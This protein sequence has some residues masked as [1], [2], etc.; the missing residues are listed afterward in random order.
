MSLFGHR[1]V[2][3]VNERQ[4]ETRRN[5]LGQG[6]QLEL[7]RMFLHHKNMVNFACN[8]FW[9]KGE[10]CQCANMHDWSV[11]LFALRTELL[12][13]EPTKEYIPILLGAKKMMDTQVESPCPIIDNCK[14]QRCWTSAPK[15]QAN[16]ERPLV[17]SQFS[18]FSYH[19]CQPN[20]KKLRL[21]HFASDVLAG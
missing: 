16:V 18:P 13:I 4:L 10:I 21:T 3:L 7:R 9:F 12:I 5:M 2:C 11:F 6:V 20:K 8:W 14:M 15:R 1:N 17:P 19:T